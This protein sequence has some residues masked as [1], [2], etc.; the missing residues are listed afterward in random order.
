MD[1]TAVS[2]ISFGEQSSL[3]S[4]HNTKVLGRSAAP[5]RASER[6]SGYG[7]VA[8]LGLAQRLHIGFLP[9]T[10][11]EPLGP[12]GK[13]GQAGIN[14]ALINIQMSFAFKHFDYKWQDPFREVVQEMVVLSNRVLRDHKHIVRLEGL[15]WDIR[16]STEVRPVLVFQKTALG[17]FHKFSKLEKFKSLSIEDKLNLCADV[18]IA[19]G[20]M[21]RNGII[22]GDIKPGN[23]LIFEDD[24]RVTAK[25]ADFGFATCLQ[26][27]KELLSMPISEPWNAPEYSDHLFQPESARKMDIYSFALLCAWLLFEAG[28][29]SG[30]SLP[31]DINLK[32]DQYVSFEPRQ[33][34][35][36]LLE[37]WKKDSSNKLVKCLSG[38]NLMPNLD[39]WSL[40]SYLAFS[41]L[42]ESYQNLNLFK[43]SRLRIKKNL[44]FIIPF[45]TY[46]TRTSDCVIVF[47]KV[48]DWWP[49]E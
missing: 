22:H 21:H 10:W 29:S 17:D 49:P 1:T 3:M 31:R 38:L 46:T 12:I 14:Q 20:D 44:S 39:A 32:T 19:I 7:F 23:V 24:S 27:G 9:I 43:S 48:L 5:V 8:V 25:V 45:S 41:F 4:N 35:K 18:G 2:S 47:I 42:T 13:G 28:S 37:L 40:D 34:G 30:F 33:S 16:S 15:C 6:Y 11:H 36:N 26:S